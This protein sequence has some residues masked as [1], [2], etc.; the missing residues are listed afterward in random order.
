MFLQNAICLTLP[1]HDYHFVEH[2][3]YDVNIYHIHTTMHGEKDQSK[4]KMQ[5]PQN[6]IRITHITSRQG[7]WFDECANM[8]F[9]FR[10]HERKR[11]QPIHNGGLLL[12][13]V[14]SV[15]EVYDVDGVVWHR[16]GIV[17]WR[18]CVFLSG[19]WKYVIFRRFISKKNQQQTEGSN[20]SPMCSDC[21]DDWILDCSRISCSG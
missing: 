14:A 21:I 1:H 2:I 7:Y 20:Q 15:W 3:Y 19:H 16:S 4:A 18:L 11:I 9:F 8:V 6:R 12:D 13:C 5:A 17:K 10:T